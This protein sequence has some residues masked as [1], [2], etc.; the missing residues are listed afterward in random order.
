[1]LSA[2]GNAAQ[3]LWSEAAGIPAGTQGA[4]VTVKP[5]QTT[6]Y[7]VTGVSGDC[8]AEQSY[9]IQVV[10]NFNLDATNVVT[11]NGDGINDK[12]VIRNIESYPLNV[13]KIFDR[14]GR[15]MYTKSGYLNEWDGTVN[16]KPLAEGTYYYAIDLGN[17]KKVFKG[18]ITIIR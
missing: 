8:T 6:T 1:M 12:W 17:G 7:T 18:F 11:P 15:L 4:T 10:E 9:T 14:S 5:V 13:V 16:G 2:T 3:Y